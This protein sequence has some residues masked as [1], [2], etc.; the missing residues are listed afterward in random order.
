MLADVLFDNVPAD[1]AQYFQL[2]KLTMINRPS[3]IDSVIVRPV[4][5]TVQCCTVAIVVASASNMDNDYNYF[6][7]FNYSFIVKN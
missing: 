2:F 7:S 5:F 1:P 3:D 6:T 4:Y